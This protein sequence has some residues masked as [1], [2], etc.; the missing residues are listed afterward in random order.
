MG[1][2]STEFATTGPGLAL[3]AVIGPGQAVAQASQGGTI[4]QPTG[5]WQ[6]PEEPAGGDRHFDMQLISRQRSARP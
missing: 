1:Q 6:V 5:S 2:W 4:H 3:L